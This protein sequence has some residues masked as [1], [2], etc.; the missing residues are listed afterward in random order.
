MAE[1][2]KEEIK[3]EETRDPLP[4]ILKV[5]LGLVFLVLGL[6]ALVHWYPDGVGNIN[7]VMP[8]IAICQ[9]VQHRLRLPPH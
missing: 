3:K 6:V 5:L 1:G 2:I 8:A 9:Q 7:Q 4:T